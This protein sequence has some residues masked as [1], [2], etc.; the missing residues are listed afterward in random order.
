MEVRL[1]EL[2]FYSIDPL[3]VLFLQYVMNMLYTIIGDAFAV[4]INRRINAHREKMQT[5]QQLELDPQVAAAWRQS[6]AISGKFYFNLWDPKCHRLTMNF[7]PF[8]YKGPIPSLDEALFQA[9]KKQG[10]DC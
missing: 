2:L 4:E 10:R 1:L 7:S 8:R 6:T 3:P 9:P 5:D